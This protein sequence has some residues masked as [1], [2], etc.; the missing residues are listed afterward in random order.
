LGTDRIIFRPE[1]TERSNGGNGRMNKPT[2]TLWQG[3]CL[4]YMKSMESKSVDLTVTSPPYNSGGSNLG[5]HPNSTVGQSFYDDYE[6]NLPDDIYTQWVIDTIGLCIAKSRYVFWNMQFL[7]RTKNAIIQAITKYADQLK[8]IFIWEKQAVAQIVPSCM[9]CGFEFVFIFGEDGTVGRNFKYTNFPSNG[10]VPNIQTWYKTE[11]FK[12]HHATFPKE[13]PLYFI[14]RFSKAGDTIFDPFMG[15]G[16][17]GVAC[18]L[19]RRNFVG[20]E[21]SKQYFDLAKRRIDSTEWG[22]FE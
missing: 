17:T 18:K 7:S 13:M 6:D 12:E 11:S 1:T 9:A 4:E 8:D 2:I 15:S 19:L 3:D 16:T 10:Y 20:C 14:E 21:I 22:M 5:Y